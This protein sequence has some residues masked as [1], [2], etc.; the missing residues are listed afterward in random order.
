MGKNI[1]EKSI[2]F[3]G[4]KIVIKE[5]GA[6]PYEFKKQIVVE[7]RNFLYGPLIPP[8]TYYIHESERIK[9]ELKKLRIRLRKC[10]T[11]SPKEKLNF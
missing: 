5:G 6:T 7:K 11:K 10:K 2:R 8:L 4:E 3:D 9:K 1:S